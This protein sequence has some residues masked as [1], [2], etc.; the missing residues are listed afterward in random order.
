MAASSD[1]HESLTCPRPVCASP[2][3][4][5]GVYTPEGRFHALLSVVPTHGRLETREMLG[6]TVSLDHD[7]VDGAPAAWFNQ[8]FRELTE[9]G[10]GLIE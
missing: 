6:L 5:D 3:L 1:L 10:H 9:S 8:T 7:V 4:L 2:W